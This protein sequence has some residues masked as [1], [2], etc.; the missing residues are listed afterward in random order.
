ETSLQAFREKFRV[1][2]AVAILG[3]YQGK[4]A[5]SGATIELQQPDTPQL[6]PHPDAG[7][8]PHFVV[9]RVKY[10]DSAPWP[11]TADGQG[12]SLQRCQAGSYGSEPLNWAGAPLT[13]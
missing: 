10:S 11:V 3:P 13:A 1:P 12:D 8:V 5:N 4:L 6:P 2:A 7:F 9:D